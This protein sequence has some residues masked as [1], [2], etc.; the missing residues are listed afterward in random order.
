M[1]MLE[2]VEGAHRD[3][4]LKAMKASTLAEAVIQYWSNFLHGY[5]SN[6]ETTMSDFLRIGRI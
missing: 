6:V 3:E 1:S 5:M 2:T 4:E